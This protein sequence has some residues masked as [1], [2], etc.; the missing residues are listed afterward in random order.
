MGAEWAGAAACVSRAASQAAL[1]SFFL[2]INR[3]SS[4]ST[5]LLPF[6]RQT[7][8]L[9]FSHSATL[10]FGQTAQNA[11]RISILRFLT[12]LKPMSV[13]YKEVSMKFR[14]FDDLAEVLVQ[15]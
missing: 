5:Q 7:A 10:I 6:G 1:G 3:V 12:R 4:L 9:H 14:A 15:V 11:K 2:S 13:A 8:N